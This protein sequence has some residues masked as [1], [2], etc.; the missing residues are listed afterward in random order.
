MSAA[1]QLQV[2]VI[3]P[4]QTYVGK[5]GVHLRRRGLGRDRGRPAHR[6]QRAAD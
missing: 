6:H 3:R 1:D 4:G 2:Q 5:Q